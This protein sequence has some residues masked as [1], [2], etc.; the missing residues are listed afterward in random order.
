MSR[1]GLSF[2]LL[3][4]GGVSGCMVGPD[5]QRPT[6]DPGAGYIAG[7]EAAP[8]K[9]P[10]QALAY[11]ADVPGRWWELFRNKPLDTLMQQAI[12]K[13]PDLD[14][15]RAAL[16]QAN[17]AALGAQGGL[18]PSVSLSSSAT[19]TDTD[20]SSL[21]GSGIY[22]IY[23][24]TPS[25]SYS[26]DLFGGTRR[27][28]EAAQATAEAQGFTAE[29]TYL[30]VT[31]NL[32]K[33]IIQEASL[34]EQIQALNEVIASYKQ[35]LGVLGNQVNVGTASRANLLQQQAALAQAQANLPAMQKALAQQQ[36]AIAALIGDFPSQYP[37]Q[38][39]RLSSLALPHKLPVSLPSAL[40]EQRPDIRAAEAALHRASASIGV[41][42]AAMLPQITL[43]AS[44]PS[45]AAEIG[46]LF[47]AANTG[48]A[49]A[50]SLAQPIFAGGKLLHSKRAADAAYE[51]ALANYRSVVLSAFKDVANAMKAIKHDNEA[52]VAYV[53][54]EKAASDSLNLARSLYTAG[55]SSYTEVL[56]AQTTYQSARMNRAAAEADR[57][58][59]AVV[60]FQALG[61]GWWNRPDNLVALAN[62][63]PSKTMPSVSRET[64]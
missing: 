27:S 1:L 42:Q 24:V 2:C 53:A 28:I 58:L 61:G 60:L 12:S 56:A 16:K 52:L 17:E 32:A 33:A 50:G 18:W 21:A 51:E 40:V 29:A 59:D 37:A 25:A 14:S 44:L 7:Q 43:S 55:T 10:V 19:R 6:L 34:R 39:F 22:T 13:N 9:A 26:L 54:A 49:L 3:V 4:A 36:N 8:K 23:S 62:T 5:F 46:S 20:G 30:T 48:W 31:S 41:A 11:G 38:P 57:Y 35:L 47:T 15:A 64:K 63:D 45:T